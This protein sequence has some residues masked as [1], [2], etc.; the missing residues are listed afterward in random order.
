MLY[1]LSSQCLLT[2]VQWR[3]QGG[4]CGF[5]NTQSMSFSAPMHNSCM[6]L[7]LSHTPGCH[8]IYMYTTTQPQ[9]AT[10]VPVQS[11]TVCHSYMYT[12]CSIGLILLCTHT[13]AM[14]LGMHPVLKT[15]RDATARVNKKAQLHDAKGR[16]TKV[17]ILDN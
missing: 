3:R 16:A 15:A 5:I 2:R 9:T 1:L 4:A 8:N 10:S 14:S 6:C 12:D 13:L 7:L 11:C 17:L